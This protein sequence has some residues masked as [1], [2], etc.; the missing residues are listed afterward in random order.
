[1]EERDFFNETT[2]LRTHTLVCPK[3]GQAAEYKVT[4]V[5]RRKRAQLPRKGRR[6]RPCPLRQSAVLHGK[7]RRQT[8]LRQRPLPQALRD[9]AIAIAGV[10]DRVASH[11]SSIFLENDGA[12]APQRQMA[13]LIVLLPLDSHTRGARCAQPDLFFE[14]KSCIIHFVFIA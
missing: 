6:A 11:C 4:W 5:V 14:E 13:T 9:Y 12:A 7:T 1:M 2:E 10:P 8:V 3:C